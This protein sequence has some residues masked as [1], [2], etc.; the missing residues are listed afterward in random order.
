MFWES[1]GLLWLILKWS[2]ENLVQFNPVVSYFGSG[3]KGNSYDR[4][5]KDE[6]LPWPHGNNSLMEKDRTYVY[7]VALCAIGGQHSWLKRREPS[8]RVEGRI[9]ILYQVAE[10]SLCQDDIHTQTWRKG[11]DQTM[12]LCEGTALRDQQT[13][14]PWGSNTPFV[15]GGGLSDEAKGRGR[16]KSKM[17]PVGARHLKEL[18]GMGNLDSFWAKTLCVTAT[19]EITT[20]CFLK[21]SHRSK[22]ISRPRH[23]LSWKLKPGMSL[24]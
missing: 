15:W 16:E 18:S 20:L 19:F 5:K 7:Q 24:S 11:V 13:Q 10:L 9:I 23:K 17:Q 12:G 21:T 14:R 6:A 22:N 2:W 8:V 1:C 3:S 4:K